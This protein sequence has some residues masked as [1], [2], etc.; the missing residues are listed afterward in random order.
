MGTLAATAKECDH[1]EC[2][3]SGLC[4]YCHQRPV[5][6]THRYNPPKPGQTMFTCLDCCQVDF[7]TP[8]EAAAMAGNTLPKAE[9]VA[10]P[11][12]LCELLGKSPH[13][14]QLALRAD[15]WE[16]GRYGW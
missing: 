15:E 14:L 3:S 6:H 2:D 5:R 9:P 7:I 11:D 16:M 12:L 13:Y 4:T 1:F 8:A 10:L